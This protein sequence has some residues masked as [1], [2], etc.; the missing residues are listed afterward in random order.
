MTVGLIDSGIGLLKTSACLRELR[1]ELDLL[2][3]MDPAGAPWGPKS[4]RWVIERVL[5]TSQR[6]V[7]MGAQILVLPCNTASVTALAHVRAHLGDRVPVVG[8]VPA[9]K[10][11]AAAYE[12]IAV[13]ATETTAASAYQARLID[14]F[15]A[16]CTVTSVACRGLAHAIDRGDKP[17][18]SAAI[19]EAVASTPGDVEAA[20]LG[21]THY[22]LVADEIASA[23]PPGVRLF[24][25][26]DAVA[27]QT[28]RKMEQLSIS[29]AGT[30][31]VSILLSGRPGSLPASALEHR[32]GRLLRVDQDLL[33]GTT[34]GSA[35][36]I[37]PSSMARRKADGWSAVPSSSKARLR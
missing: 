12:R 8:T 9:I 37:R 36:L 32:E 33:S 18:I 3:M 25:S 10:P 4:G 27:R 2:L 17:A 31:R 16:G 24:D 11:A 26:A 5:D 15:A 29:S 22:P 13:W 23:L 6:A 28:L 7:A 35:Q 30:G 21:C 19:V 20:V 34:V 14:E 1:P